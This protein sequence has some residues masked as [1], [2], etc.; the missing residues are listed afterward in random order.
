MAKTT[1][2][3]VCQSRIASDAKI[4]YVCGVRIKKPFYIQTWFLVTI[5][6][7][8]GVILIVMVKQKL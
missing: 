4:C 5:L 3:M 6:I 7:V 1:Y 8:V 2:C